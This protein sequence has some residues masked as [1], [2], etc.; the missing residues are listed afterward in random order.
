MGENERRR[1]VEEAEVLRIAEEEKASAK[2]RALEAKQR[3]RAEEEFKIMKIRRSR[4]S[5]SPRATRPLFLLAAY[6]F[7]T[8]REG[9]LP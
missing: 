6:A 8:H 3:E 9:A 1:L 2:Q 5:D 4:T 7:A